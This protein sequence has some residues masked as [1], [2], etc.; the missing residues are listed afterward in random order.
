MS[1]FAERLGTEPR[2]GLVASYI[3]G[4]ALATIGM[5]L[6]VVLIVLALAGPWLVPHDP[7]EQSFLSASQGPSGEYW[8]G[9]D[10]FGRD[11]F[12]RVLLG[13]QASLAVG[14]SA[15]LTRAQ[16]YTNEFVPSGAEY[17][18]GPVSGAFSAASF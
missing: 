11:V 1:G 17:R 15:P 2:R 5:V 18:P 3:A 7:L 9:T 14:V 6:A 12:S 8:F 10:S 16:L 4:N 13:T